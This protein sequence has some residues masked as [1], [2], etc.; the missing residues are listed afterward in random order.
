MVHSLSPVIANALCVM[1]AAVPMKAGISMGEGSND[2]HQNGLYAALS[3][4][5]RW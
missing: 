1:E 4:G 3:E 2:H 5:T